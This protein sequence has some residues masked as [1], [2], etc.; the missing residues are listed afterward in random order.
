MDE[1][2][3]ANWIIGRISAYAE[4]VSDP[5]SYYELV[6]LRK[7]IDFFNET[8]RADFLSLNK[9]CVRM[10][11][12]TIED[13]KLD[14]AECVEARSGLFIPIEWQKNYLE[15]YES[16]LGWMI[17]HCAQSAM[18]FDPTL[19]ESEPWQSPKVV[20]GFHESVLKTK[21]KTVVTPINSL[22]EFNDLNESFRQFFFCSEIISK[23]FKLIGTFAGAYND[24]LEELSIS[25]RTDLLGVICAFS[26]LDDDVTTAWFLCLL[27]DEYLS[28]E[29][30]DRDLLRAFTRIGGSRVLP[31]SR[32]LSEGLAA[33]K[34][35]STP[36]DYFL[37]L[38]LALDICLLKLG[39][40]PIGTMM[41]S[42]RSL[43]I[44]IAVD[45][46]SVF[47]SKPSE[48]SNFAEFASTLLQRIRIVRS[49][50]AE[51]N[52]LD[53][54]VREISDC[55]AVSLDPDAVLRIMKLSELLEGEF[56]S[57][58]M[59]KFVQRLTILKL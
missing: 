20:S 42:V 27:S 9:R 1:E 54:L 47:S 2:N 24:K 23:C 30:D 5:F 7:S 46:S 55:K 53:D 6:L 45:R 58:W 48:I 25:A 40:P 11:R 13:E 37:D 28:N 29:L 43:E 12:E 59:T 35:T 56:L 39:V 31:K 21:A 49:F 36:S 32:L 41:H 14:R 44:A 10:I 38:V 15:V 17:S 4:A 3:S 52:S 22:V 19:G 26:D 57:D 34:I 33:P 51:Q 8:N 50:N 18:M 16:D